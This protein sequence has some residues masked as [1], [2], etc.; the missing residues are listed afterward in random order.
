MRQKIPPKP[1][2]QHKVR[3]PFPDIEFTGVGF[4]CT[5]YDI[6]VDKFVTDLKDGDEFAFNDY[7]RNY[8]D[9]LA[10]SLCRWAAKRVN[11]HAS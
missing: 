2:D 3:A 11:K 5:R 10:E 9:T 8:C 4:T 1:A 7:I 6:V